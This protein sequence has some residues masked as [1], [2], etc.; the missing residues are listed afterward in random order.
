VLKECESTWTHVLVDEFQD[1]SAQQYLFLRLIARHQRITVVGDD[2][3]SIFSF[4]GANSG[5]F[6]AFRKDFVGHKEVSPSEP[7]PI[8]EVCRKLL[9]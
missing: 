9:R 3:Q 8:E 1:T 2:D 7:F 6:G 5:G 4:N